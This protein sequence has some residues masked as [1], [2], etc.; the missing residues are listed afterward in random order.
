M[1]I[2]EG[3]TR[4]Y[5]LAVALG[6]EYIVKWVAFVCLRFMTA[7]KTDVKCWNEREIFR[8]CEFPLRLRL[9][10]GISVA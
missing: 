1:V 3:L 8:L 7:T 4:G 5:G 6:R 10:S 9:M 2:W